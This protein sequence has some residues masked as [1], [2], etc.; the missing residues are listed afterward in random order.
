MA[1]SNERSALP[2]PPPLPAVLPMS[3]VPA[4]VQSADVCGSVCAADLLKPGARPGGD[5]SAPCEIANSIT[6][7]LGL[8]LSVVAAV[9]LMVAARHCD[10]WQWA[11]CGIYVGT[12][13][14]VYAAS[15][16]SHVFQEPRRQQFFRMLDQGC[17][18][19]F[20]AGTFTPIAAAY[21]REDNWWVLLSAMWTIALGGFFSKVVFVHRIH[22]ASVA[23][24]VLLGWMP[25][26]GGR[27][28]LELIPAQLAWWMLAGGICYTVGTLFLVYDYRHRY[29]HAVWHLFVI[30]GSACHFW[31][32]LR[33]ALPAA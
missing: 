10:F 13:V 6:H 18:Y 16:L 19:L 3:G 28:M 24:P 11:T 14:S 25:L 32:I 15:T 29:L 17:I 1:E 23:V 30:A 5:Y 2:I 26:M 31:A 9:V 21:L 8:V 20:I 4:T 7:G 27:P 12:M 22:A 33:Y